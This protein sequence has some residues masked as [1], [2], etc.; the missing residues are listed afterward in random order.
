MTKHKVQLRLSEK[1]KL[2]VYEMVNFKNKIGLFESY[3]YSLNL[4]TYNLFTYLKKPTYLI[5]FNNYLSTY[6]T[7]VNILLAI[8]WMI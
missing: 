5:E 2:D 1:I 7:L 6:V 8:N 4:P 3:L